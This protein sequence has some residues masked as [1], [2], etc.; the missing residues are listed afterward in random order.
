[1]RKDQ[2]GIGLGQV[3]AGIK[4]EHAGGSDD[5]GHDEREI[6]SAVRGR[7]QGS[8]GLDRPRAAKVPRIVARAAAEK[9]IITVFSAAFCHCSPKITWLYQRREYAS[10]VQFQHAPGKGK[11]GS[12]L[13]DRG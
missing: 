2:G 4:E 8:A 6:S 9:P 11:I 12:A 3:Q 7:R 10:G 5:N 13:K 1:M